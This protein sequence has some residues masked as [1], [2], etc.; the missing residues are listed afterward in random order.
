M[1]NRTAVAKAEAVAAE[2]GRD[3]FH[4]A[5]KL[6]FRVVYEHLPEGCDEMVLPDVRVMFLRP[7]HRRDAETAR[8]VVAHALGHVFLHAGDQTGLLDPVLPKHF[9]V[10]HER[11]AEAFALALLYGS[12]VGGAY[13]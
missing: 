11:Q 3:P 8:R 7:E 1:N 13:R 12:A 4:I 6:G 9:F 10:G 2:H 5:R